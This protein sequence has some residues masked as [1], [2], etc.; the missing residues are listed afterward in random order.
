MRTLSLCLLFLYPVFAKAEDG[1]KV[2]CRFVSLNA[3]VPPP[4]LLTASADGAES[5]VTV[6]TGSLSAASPCFSK[7]NT[8]SFLS[9][10]DRTPAATATIPADV[11]SAI[12]VFVAAPKTPGT[13]PWRVF[14]IEDSPKNFPDGGAFVANFHNQDIRFVIGENK[15][16]LHAAGSH[17]VSRPNER[18]EFNMAPVAFQFLQGDSWKNASESMMRF[19]PGMRYLMFAFVDSASGRP[20]VVTFQDQSTKA[21][22]PAPTP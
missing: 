3:E 12:L 6:P 19:L 9:A 5:S 7:T 17:G 16:M 18:D 11:K 10:A 20:R 15:I 14:V 2:E 1:R 21:V 13:L 22:A 8:F 4:A